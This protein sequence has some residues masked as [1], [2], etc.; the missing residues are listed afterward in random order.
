MP[1]GPLIVDIDS[2]TLTEEE[3]DY[4]T[5]PFVGG[6]IL[7]SKNYSCRDD[8]VALIKRIKDLRHPSL[9]IFVDQEG[10]RVQRFITDFTDLPALGTL[11]AYYERDPEKAAI[12]VR[13][14]GWMMATELKSVGVDVSFAPV[15]DRFNVKS[16]VIGNRAFHS[17]PT[18]ICVLAGL[19]VS[20][21]HGCGMHAVGKHFPGHGSVTTDSHVALPVDERSFDIIR[22]TDL[23]PFEFMIS[24]GLS[25]LMAAHIA[26][27]NI[28]ESAVVGFSE[29][30]LQKILRKKLGFNGL[31]FSDDLSMEGAAVSSSYLARA[32]LAL[33]AGCD[34]LIVCNNKIGIFEILDNYSQVSALGQ[35]RS[36]ELMRGPSCEMSSDVLRATSSWIVAKRHIEDFISLDM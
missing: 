26:F 27:P 33:S 12:I 32:N 9:L 4:L 24:C 7:F 23:L 1:L 16:E 29:L 20:V 11:G 10:G 14:S 28:D 5:H 21:M 22:K 34:A 15:L 36:L 13:E 30:W 18:I 6:V 2:V 17:D 35:T 25:G 3:S 31:I 19:Y 8:L